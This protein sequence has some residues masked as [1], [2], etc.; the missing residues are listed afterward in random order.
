MLLF[1]SGCLGWDGG[2]NNTEVHFL[3]IYRALEKLGLEENRARITV[4]HA[5]TKN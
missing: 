3:A 4:G 1:A 5:Y 2:Y